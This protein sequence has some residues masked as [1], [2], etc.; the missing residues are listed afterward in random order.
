LLASADGANV[1]ANKTA[2]AK[3]VDFVI[4]EESLKLL[5]HN[6]SRQNEE[7]RRK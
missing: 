2:F 6:C 7:S 5:N 1:A 4:I 3:H